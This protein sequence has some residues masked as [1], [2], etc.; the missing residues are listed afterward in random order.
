MPKARGQISM[1]C[2]IQ[3]KGTQAAFTP[4]TLR[5]CVMHGTLEEDLSATV[6]CKHSTHSTDGRAISTVQRRSALPCST[7]R[8]PSCTAPAPFETCKEPEGCPKALLPAHCFPCCNIDYFLC[9]LAPSSCGVL[10]LSASACTPS[11]SIS[12][13]SSWYTMRC[14]AT[15]GL[16]SKA[17]DTTSTL[18]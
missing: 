9:H 14:R 13:C 3:L 18:K 1:Q 8:C 2:K 16:P 15:K 17:A 11:T 6:H 4:L 12:C 7:R 5:S 10:V